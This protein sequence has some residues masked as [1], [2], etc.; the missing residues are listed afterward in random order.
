[1]KGSQWY[2][3]AAF[4]N[5]CPVQSGQ[6]FTYRFPVNEIPGTYIWHAHTGAAST[7]GLAGPLIVRPPTGRKDP[8]P[9]PPYDTEYIMFI[10][11]WYHVISGL[12]TVGLNR[13][14]TAPADWV[15]DD[16][17]FTWIGNPQAI[18]INGKGNAGDCA[19][20]PAGSPVGTNATCAVVA[21]PQGGC[22]HEEYEVEAGKTYLFRVINIGGLT[23]QTVCFEGHNVT[24]VAADAVPVDPIVAKCI[25]INIGQRYD[26]IL[27]ANQAAGAYWISSQTQFRPGSPSGY[28][29][30]RY[31]GAVQPATLPLTQAPQPGSVDIWP[32]EFVSQL[33]LNSA[34]LQPNGPAKNNSVYE[35]ATTP[36]PAATTYLLVNI[37]QP[38]LN[39]TGQ[40]RWAMNNIANLENPPCNNLQSILYYNP[41]WLPTNAE[42]TETAGA[43]ASSVGLGQQ[44]GPGQPAAVFIANLTSP[45]AMAVNPKA[46]AHVA[47]VKLGE[48]VEIVI[49]NNGA[50]SFNGAGGNRTAQEQHPFHLHGHHFWVMGVGQGIYP[51]PEAVA[52]SGILNTVNP[53]LRDTQTLPRNGFIVVR[54]L[55]NNPGTWLLH[56]HIPY[57][58]LM[59]QAMAIAE[60]TELVPRA[61]LGMPKC[62][63]P[64]EYSAAPYNISYTQQVFGNYIPSPPPRP[65]ALPTSQREGPA[66]SSSIAPV[67]APALPSGTA[68]STMMAH[69]VFYVLIAIFSS[70]CVCLPTLSV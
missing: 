69:G 41:N 4:V 64:C 15:P 1:M 22:T 38:V 52:A 56:C 11:D 20:P 33:K 39:E 12:Q 23:Y 26:V 54:F 30:L 2:D 3:G 32:T 8:V 6:N 63:S 70:L 31:K 25:D 10:H 66:S 18:L 17:N 65:I 7:N 60:A 34:F 13:P 61:P 35:I 46:G 67:P 14:F 36:V 19:A 27:T 48:V 37:S 47:P 51:G 44:Y 58:Q 45:K 16:G 57:H 53:P 29:V 40:I 21:Q 59:G 24:I 49:Q 68:V 50:S 28:A 5:M 55:A 62:P 43:N 42:L 9:P